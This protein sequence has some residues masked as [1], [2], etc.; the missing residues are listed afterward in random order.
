MTRRTLAFAFLFALLISTGYAEDPYTASTLVKV[1]D[2][3]PDVACTTL[4]GNSVSMRSLKGKVILINFFATWC[5]ACR[6]ELPRLENEIFR[7]IKSDRFTIIA[8]GRGQ[9]PEELEEFRTQKKI[10][11]PLVADPDRMI[12]GKFATKYIPRNF[13]IGK[14]GTIRW[15]STGY[16]EKKFKQM[17][18]IIKD[19][20]AAE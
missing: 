13:V 9:K 2:A 6:K 5:E 16:D 17:I 15:S 3:V 8:I 14:N 7:K 20:L 18:S 12:Y 11:L 4:D 19:E 10:T 1:G